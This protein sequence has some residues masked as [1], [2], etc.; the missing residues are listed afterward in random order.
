VTRGPEDKA[1]AAQTT[2]AV[3]VVGV[4]GSLGSGKSTLC[5]LLA[6]AGLAVIDADRVSRRVT[7]PA[8]AATAELADAFGADLL[9]GGGRLDRRRL[10]ARAFVDEASRD[11]LHALLHP[12]IRRAL[13]AEV[14]ALGAAGREVAII[15]AAMI[16]E[17]GHRAFYDML[18]VVTASERRKLERVIGRGMSE[19][20]ARRRLALQWPDDRKAAAADWVVPN[21]GDLPA[22][23]AAAEKLVAEIRRRAAGRTR[24]GRNR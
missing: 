6:G 13:R 9:D 19:A 2:P 8:T 18:V 16:L 4:T 10:A 22:L 3:Y 20:D 5:R 14:E 11:R 12:H 23:E 24:G 7:A 21:D 17:S 1:A 15:E